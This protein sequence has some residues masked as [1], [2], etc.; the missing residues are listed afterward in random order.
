ML[1]TKKRYAELAEVSLQYLNEYIKRGKI[2]CTGQK[3]D[4]CLPQNEYFLQKRAAKNM[5]PIELPDIIE[6]LEKEESKIQYDN[7]G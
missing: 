2:I 3:I 1:Y 5:P 4:D 6:L 7:D